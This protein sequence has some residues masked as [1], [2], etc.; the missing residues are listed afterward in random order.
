MREFVEFAALESARHFG[1]LPPLASGELRP[2]LLETGSDSYQNEDEFRRIPASVRILMFADQV[3]IEEPF[4]HSN[5]R[6]HPEG[7]ASLFEGLMQVKSLANDGLQFVRVETRERHPSRNLGLF[8][9]KVIEEKLLHEYGDE[10]SSA[11]RQHGGSWDEELFS[12]SLLN[13][14]GLALRT[15]IAGAGSVH[16]LSRTKLEDVLAKIAI[17]NGAI[18]SRRTESL[19]LQDLVRVPVPDV[20]LPVESLVRLRSNEDAWHEWRVALRTALSEV[21]QLPES[22][23]WTSTANEMLN[24]ELAGVTR[25][26]QKAAAKSPAMTAAKVTSRTLTLSAIGSFA[27]FVAGGSL[28]PG[29]VGAGSGKAAEAVLTYLNS[30]RE[31]RVQ[32]AALDVALSFHV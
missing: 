26:L 1:T 14:F 4:I 28:I 13:K 23:R 16:A 21:E 29:L 20:G 8:G 6:Q 5:L 2:L 30:R 18:L 17:A 15:V 22:E 12:F 25:R 32:K 11:A 31:Q 9:P 10:L 7:L 24:D 19:R 3:A 27:G